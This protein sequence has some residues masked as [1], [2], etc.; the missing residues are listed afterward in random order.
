MNQD[1]EEL[2][3]FKASIESTGTATVANF[4]VTSDLVT[5]K[6]EKKTIV[7]TKYT[8]SVIEPSYG[9]GRILYSVLEHSFSQRNGD[10]Q[11]CVM[12]F[13]PCVAPIKVYFMCV[14]VVVGSGGEWGAGIY[15]RICI[16]SLSINT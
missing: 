9:V 4:N 11:R 14:V 16:N 10:E 12:A 5:F 8:P 3:A 6:S 2:D 13:R 15:V 7:E 1:G